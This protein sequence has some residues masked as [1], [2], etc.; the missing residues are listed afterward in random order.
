MCAL[1]GSGHK[2]NLRPDSTPHPDPPQGR[3]FMNVFAV[4]RLGQKVSCGKTVDKSADS[5]L[6][7]SL[8]TLFSSTL[9][10]LFSITGETRSFVCKRRLECVMI[11]MGCCP[12]SCV[13]P[14]RPQRQPLKHR[15]ARGDVMSGIVHTVTNSASRRT[16]AAAL[17]ALAVAFSPHADK[18]ARRVRMKWT[19]RTRAGTCSP[20]TMWRRAS[21]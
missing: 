1:G 11:G 4:E 17:L 20:A 5:W 19:C 18:R 12:L 16:V 15:R 10:V 3:P 13:H 9:G 8:L 14:L 7:Q 21:I 2:T 6:P